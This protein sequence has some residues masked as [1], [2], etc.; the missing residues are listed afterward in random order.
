M[1]SVM[2]AKTKVI[3]TGGQAALIGRASQHIETIDEFLTLD[4]LRIIWERNHA[5]SREQS[6]AAKKSSA[7]ARSE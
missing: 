1:K 4:G 5:G 6:G 2:G 3:A 7:P